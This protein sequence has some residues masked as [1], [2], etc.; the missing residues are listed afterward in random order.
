M[1]AELTLAPLTSGLSAESLQN[2]DVNA[3]T[4]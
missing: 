2:A 1:P 4:G 3:C